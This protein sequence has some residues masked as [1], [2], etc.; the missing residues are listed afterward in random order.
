VILREFNPDGDTGFIVSSW[1]KAIYF[2][3]VSEPETPWSRWA[4]EKHEAIKEILGTHTVRVATLVDMPELI[5]GYA[6]LG[7]DPGLLEFVYVK[8]M[9]RKIGVGRLLTQ[10]LVTFQ[11]KNATHAGLAFAKAMKLRAAV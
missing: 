11:P 9:Y 3:S 5:V 7:V 4:D 10:G 1:P 2:G 6:V 8:K